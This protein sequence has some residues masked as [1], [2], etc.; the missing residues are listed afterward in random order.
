MKIRDGKST[1][2]LVPGPSRKNSSDTEWF[3]GCLDLGI[4]RPE[5][6]NETAK[7][8]ANAGLDFVVL[9]EDRQPDFFLTYD[10]YNPEAFV[11][12]N[13]HGPHSYRSGSY[14]PTQKD[15][16]QFVK[17]M[18]DEGIGVMFGF[19]MHE[20]RWIL[21]RHPELLLT[22]IN[23]YQWHTS[24]YSADFNPLLDFQQ[25]DNYHG[26]KKGD[27]FADYVC[28]QYGR[29]SGDFGFRGLFVGDG[30]MGF[31]VFGDDSLG[32]N[33]Y[34]YSDA[35]LDRFARST[36]CNASSHLGKCLLDQASAESGPTGQGFAKFSPT[37]KA[38]HIRIFHFDEFAQ[39]AC[40]EWS[41]FYKR[42]ANFV[43]SANGL[44]G[45]YS[46]M[47]YGPAKARMHG[48]DY[49]E[50]ARSGLDYLVFQ[51]YGYAWGKHFGLPD[52]DIVANLDQLLSLRESMCLNSPALSTK[53][54]FTA[55]TS[56]S[57]ES[58]QCPLQET[59]DQV[60]TYTSGRLRGPDNYNKAME[61][62]PQNGTASQACN[63]H[64]TGAFIVWLNDVMPQEIYKI[65]ETVELARI[66]VR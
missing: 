1:N 37:E 2:A 54:L 28:M 48:V 33:H 58:W 57:V 7:M 64:R 38:R 14:Y 53:I 56:D 51:T 27:S 62:N 6:F 11:G 29:L 32:T 20:N 10:G 23:G 15:L 4:A 5:K 18:L 52:K 24:D 9:M 39:W 13:R 47:N 36:F 30:G 49:V 41:C 59:L 55:E 45:A 34:D 40:S 44:L 25:E 3:A 65:R 35:S 61:Q 22:D 60:W 21:R 66:N 46:C 50:I 17:V 19:W 26:I 42:L 8:L 16:K 63:L 12:L 43:H 31:R